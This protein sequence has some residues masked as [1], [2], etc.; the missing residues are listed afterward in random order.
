MDRDRDVSE[1]RGIAGHWFSGNK[2]LARA[3]IATFREVPQN[4]LY[5]RLVAYTQDDWARSYDWLDT[6]GLEL[7]FL[8]RLKTLGI[9]GAVPEDVRARM[10]GNFADNRV[11]TAKMLEEFVRINHAFLREELTYCNVKGI[12]LAPASCP[13]P[14]LR[15]QVNLDFIMSTSDSGRCQDVLADLGY[16]AHLLGEH[17]CEFHAKRD[18]PHP[19]MGIYRTTT[20]HSIG[21]YLVS[22]DA[23]GVERAPYAMLER[24]R[25]KTWN[26]HAF[27]APA[28]SD[29]FIAL[30]IRMLG[31]LGI[32][33]TRLAFLLEFRN[34]IHFWL[35]D[36]NF[37]REVTDGAQEHPLRPVAIATATR[38]S[39]EIFGGDI[40]VPI[41]GWAA[42]KLDARI[43]WWSEKYSWGALLTDFP[44]TTL[45]DLLQGPVEADT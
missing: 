35:D 22:A 29:H 8:E 16:S 27:P 30:S 26:G 32:E 24:R 12:A 1:M 44:G 11:R 40:P 17:F 33:W 5:G 9:E 13:N 37:W 34:C 36:E 23:Q 43:R 6:S 41:R 3:I 20:P 38:L 45:Q 25:M 2:H 10:E 4:D 15:R 19:G 28:E 14:A 21:I 18:A 39:A 31:Q 42:D 7:Y